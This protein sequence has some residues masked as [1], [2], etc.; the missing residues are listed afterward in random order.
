MGNAP[1][2]DKK[3]DDAAKD[4]GFKSYPSFSRSDTKD[5]RRS[6]G[7]AIR[8]KI[9][10]TGKDSPRNSGLLDV[11]DD[12]ADTASVRSA[13]STTKS[14]GTRSHRGS[15]SSQRP[16]SIDTTEAK[17]VEETAAADD[18]DD[19]PPPSPTQSATVGKGHE[20]IEAAQRSGEVDHVSDAPPSGV[21][22]HDSNA[23]PK[24]PILMMKKGVPA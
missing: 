6:I 16:A 20:D 15:G 12:K 9:P 22:L 1:S 2:K 4:P 7:S 18:D 23:K 11:P 14:N 10:S 19:E 3:G 24:E 17:K 21:P 5:S 13:Q 8:S